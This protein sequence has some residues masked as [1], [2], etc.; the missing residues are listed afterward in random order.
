MIKM[1]IKKEKIIKKKTLLKTILKARLKNKI[2]IDKRW[3]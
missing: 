1:E 2:K 3:T